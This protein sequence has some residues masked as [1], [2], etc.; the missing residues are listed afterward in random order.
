M[1][2]ILFNFTLTDD[3]IKAKLVRDFSDKFDD[4][5]NA[6]YLREMTT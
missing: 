4:H 6:N 2:F 3:L 5:F 1:Y